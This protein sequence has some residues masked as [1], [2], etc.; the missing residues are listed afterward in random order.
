MKA[1]VFHGRRDVRVEDVAEPP[2]PGPGELLLDVS[3]VGICG[4]DAVEYLHGPRFVPLHTR[5]GG[6]GHLGP[7]VLGHE[8]FGRVAAAGAGLQGFEPGQRVVSGAGVWCG[9]CDW[10]RAG[11]TNLC[12]RYYTLGLHAHGGLAERVVVPALTCEVVPDS[13]SDTAAT[14]AQPLAIALH[15]VERGRVSTG[16]SVLVIG[17]GGIGSFVV[18]AARAKGARPIIAVDTDSHRLGTALELGADVAVAAGSHAEQV[19][20][21]TGAGPDLAIE[22]TGTEEG[23]AEAI[24][25]VRRGGRLLLVGHQEE[26]RLIDLFGLN[27]RE[28]EV[29]TTLAH[30]CRRNLPESLRLLAETD[31]AERVIDRIIELED[32]VEDGLVALAERR[33]RGKILVRVRG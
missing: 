19:L 7:T 1:A 12:E 23:L 15:A 32:V 26:P 30:I 8:F 28:V 11:R 4:T 9:D 29:T 18:A 22:A 27:L 2:S 13:C 6:S 10:C 5:H 24:K 3:L 14:L 25:A 16:E 20:A 21:S 31:L 33:A 17:V